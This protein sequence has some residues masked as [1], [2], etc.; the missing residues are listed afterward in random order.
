[1]DPE[2]KKAAEFCR[3]ASVG[4]VVAS[5]PPLKPLVRYRAEDTKPANWKTVATNNG[6]AFLD[7]ISGR[8]YRADEWTS[9]EPAWWAYLPEG[10]E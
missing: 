8:W 4:H 3:I 5:K 1:M 6:L 10:D 9:T 7:P 2:T